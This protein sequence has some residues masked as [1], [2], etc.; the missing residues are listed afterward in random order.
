[1]KV[2]CAQCGSVF[3]V[4]DNSALDEVSCAQ[5][6]SRELSHDGATWS[7]VAGVHSTEAYV[8]RAGAGAAELGIPSVV[9]NYE[10]LGELAR[11]GMGVVFRARQ[12]GVDRLVALKMIRPGLIPDDE[13][14][15]RFRLEA[16]AAAQLDHPA[17]VPIF[18][19]GDFRGLPYFSM[20]LVDGINLAQA[21]RDATWDGMRAAAIM[22]C[23][24]GAIAYAHERGVIH[25]DLKPSNI[26]LDSEGQPRITDFGLAKRL[27]S[28]QEL[29]A[30]G[31]AMGTPSYMAPEQAADTSAEIG[32]RTDVYGL[33]ATLYSLLTGRPPFQAAT[34]WATLQQVLHDEPVPPRRL[35]PE[36]PRDL[37]TICL[38]CL[39]KS[40]ER[41]YG[42]AAELAADL[43]RYLEG[44]PIAAR[45]VSVLERIWRWRRR[46]PLVSGAIASTVLACV[47]GVVGISWQLH[48]TTDARDAALK[49]NDELQKSERRERAAREEAQAFAHEARAQ[50]YAVSINLA[51]RAHDEGRIEE[52]R[53]ILRDLIPSGQQP[54]SREYSWFRLWKLVHPRIGRWSD[55]GA[56]VD[57]LALAPQGKLLAF[58][59]DL[60]VVSIVDW[61]AAN[62]PRQ[63]IDPDAKGP[64]SALEF[65]P[66][67]MTLA[68]GRADGHVRLWNTATW[69]RGKLLRAR[70]VVVRDLAFHPDGGRL[71]EATA[72]TN[73][74]GNVT[75]WNISDG[76]IVLSL[77]RDIPGNPG[78]PRGPSGVA[79]SARG[80]LLAASGYDGRTRLWSFPEG[81]LRQET[82]IKPPAWV[83][84]VVWSPDDRLL[85]TPRADGSLRVWDVAAWTSLETPRFPAG[86]LVHGAMARDGRRLVIGGTSGAALWDSPSQ[87]WRGILQG[88][89]ITAVALTDDGKTA[90]TGGGDG[91]A[92]AWNLE[93]SA[94]GLARKTEPK[95]G[96][97]TALAFNRRGDR[98]AMTGYNGYVGI[99]EFPAL[100]EISSRT[101]PA[102]NTS[103]VPVSLSAQG[104]YYAWNNA[105]H[106]A[107]DGVRID[108]PREAIHPAFGPHESL[109]ALW[110]PRE[111]IVLYDL[112]TAAARKRFDWNGRPPRWMAFTQDGNQLVVL[113]DDVLH[114]F[115]AETGKS[116]GRIEG[117][118]DRLGSPVLSVT[119]NVFAALGNGRLTAWS[120]TTGKPIGWF[121]DATF[122][123]TDVDEF[124]AIS[125]D[126]RTLALLPQRYSSLVKL[127]DLESRRLLTSFHWGSGHVSTCAFTPDGGQ[128]VLAGGDST[129]PHSVGTVAVY[130]T[131]SSERVAADMRDARV[132]DQQVELLRWVQEEVGKVHA[133]LAEEEKNVEGPLPESPRN[134]Q[135]EGQARR[136]VAGVCSRL[137]DYLDDAEVEPIHRLTFLVRVSSRLASL[138]RYSDLDLYYQCRR[139]LLESSRR[140]ATTYPTSVQYRRQLAGQLIVSGQLLLGHQWQGDVERKRAAA[141]SL[142]A[143]NAARQ[144]FVDSGGESQSDVLVYE[145]IRFRAALLAEQGAADDCLAFAQAVAT[146]N[147]VLW[148]DALEAALI[149]AGVVA[150]P[151]PQLAGLLGDSV[152]RADS[153]AVLNRIE[154][155]LQQ[156]PTLRKWTDSSV[157]QQMRQQLA[158]RRMELTK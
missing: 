74:M 120:L 89:E 50:Q 6:G 4:P 141:Q 132:E 96:L 44:V 13:T 41:R 156:D 62:A 90:F 53:A 77:E 153:L 151:T 11:G 70:P 23:V 136:T 39:E 82:L 100:R 29:T 35:N 78:H 85:Y 150:E 40:P 73:G 138:Q 71:A 155:Q 98:L 130:G 158:Q 25:R 55:G 57:A 133:A 140:L 27:E 148:R 56:R 58:G 123:Y 93:D 69:E 118:A 101:E 128:L 22:K 121:D 60:G 122:R 117:R 68:V 147:V 65:A 91:V 125:P 103:H 76:T 52:A 45:P 49:A 105:I 5:C 149:V 31:Q 87:R 67:G 131:A 112:A 99:Y 3:D 113:A 145:S 15:A 84:D 124:L 63:L 97:M 92:A 126:G 9:G 86:Q 16:E 1:M 47:L 134:A 111:G 37:E 7:H 127:F 135:L 104:D 48:L 157:M 18:D 109:A 139:A 21:T 94:D 24:S 108:L 10:I 64:V 59:G 115:D 116:L 110:H 32:P 107:V 119:S 14:I 43:D 102:L 75:V 33:G 42:S 54:D 129:N 34:A 144:L 152:A 106:R 81:D 66:D 46:N 143:W 146:Q 83:N 142:E 95:T 20:A 80:E 61:R 2:E 51:Y 72:G 88:A 12:R 26:L 17:I 28:A 114:R 36:V 154:Q 79:F 19:V 8:G 137:R 30:S 38:K